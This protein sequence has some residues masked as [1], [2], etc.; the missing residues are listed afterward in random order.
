MTHFRETAA[1]VAFIATADSRNT[2]PEIMEAI[3]QLARNE[4]EAI[5]LWDGDG[6]GRVA[7]LI[8]IW[9][10]ATGNG[11]ISDEVLFWGDRSF[12][13]IMAEDA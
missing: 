13:K 11:R 5:A 6:I 10:R 8:D 7:N 9:E 4:D 12:A 1:G 2:S 3:A